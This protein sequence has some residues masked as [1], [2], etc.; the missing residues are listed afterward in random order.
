MRTPEGPPKA[1]TVYL[2]LVV[3]EMCSLVHCLVAGNCD[4]ALTS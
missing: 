4:R 1:V 3:I 2:D